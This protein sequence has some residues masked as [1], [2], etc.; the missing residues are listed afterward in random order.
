MKSQGPGILDGRR[1]LA[2]KQ[3]KELVFWIVYVS[4]NCMW[5]SDKGFLRVKK[6]E[7]SSASHPVFTGR[8]SAVELCVPDFLALLCLLATD[9]AFFIRHLHPQIGLKMFESESTQTTI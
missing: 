3:E 4:S 8:R 5:S 7:N 6:G 1:T 2:F 9:K